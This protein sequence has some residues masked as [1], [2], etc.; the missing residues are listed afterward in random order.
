MIPRLP[1]PPDF[2]LAVETLLGDVHLVR[3]EILAA[4][5]DL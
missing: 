5:G 4:M 1:L 2:A 3:K